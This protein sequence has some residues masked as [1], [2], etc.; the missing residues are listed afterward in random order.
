MP[1]VEAEAG[2]RII[3][4]HSDQKTWSLSQG[5]LFAEGIQN[6]SKNLN[7]SVFLKDSHDEVLNYS[8]EVFDRI[9]L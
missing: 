2:H 8:C 1:S 3:L 6:F 7:R 9:R 4:V 5:F